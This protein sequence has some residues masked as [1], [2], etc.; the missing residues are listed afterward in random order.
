MKRHVGI[1]SRDSISWFSLAT[2]C[3]DFFGNVL[4]CTRLLILCVAGFLNDHYNF[5]KSQIYLCLHSF[6][7]SC[8]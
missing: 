3:A 7:L 8:V 6:E 1:S 5:K 4:C 2:G